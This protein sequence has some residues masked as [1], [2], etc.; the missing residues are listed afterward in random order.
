MI[1]IDN[2]KQHDSGIVSCEIT[3]PLYW[4]TEFEKYNSIVTTTGY[5]LEHDLCNRPLNAH[6]FS[7]E[8]MH[9][10]EFIVNI[11]LDNLNARIRD[12]KAY[13]K[14]NRGLWRTIMQL[15]P[16]SYNRTKRVSVNQRT[17]RSICFTQAG[18]P[19]SE[20]HDFCTYMYD[21]LVCTK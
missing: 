10:D 4:W 8:D 16:Q 1:R 5:S 19:L 11:V 14:E 6:D 15:L 18:N 17:L 2:L 3:A 9:D 21:N 13:M 7:F 12:Y 20:W